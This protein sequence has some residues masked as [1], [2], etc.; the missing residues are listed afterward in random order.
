MNGVT[1]IT[2]HFLVFILPSSVF[3]DQINAACR[4]AVAFILNTVEPGYNDIG[5]GDAPYITSDI[6]W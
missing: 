2:R 5:L 6:L 4:F 1:F 3:L